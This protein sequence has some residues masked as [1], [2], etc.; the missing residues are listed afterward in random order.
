MMILHSVANAQLTAAFVLHGYW[1]LR[2]GGKPLG[3]VAAPR[4]AL[5]RNTPMVIPVLLAFGSLKKLGGARPFL[6]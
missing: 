5:L 2:V 1:A 4:P 3:I 6:R